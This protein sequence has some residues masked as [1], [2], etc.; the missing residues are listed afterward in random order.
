MNE[1]GRKARPRCQAESL[2]YQDSNLD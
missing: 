1:R 2:G